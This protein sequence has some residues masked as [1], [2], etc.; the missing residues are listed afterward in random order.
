MSVKIKPITG[1]EP[2]WGDVK[3]TQSQ[4]D[5]IN[6][7]PT[8]V[9][10]LQ[11]ANERVAAGT[12]QPMAINPDLP[13]DGRYIYDKNQ[14]EFAP[15]VTQQS[16]GSFVNLLA[17]E[18]GHVANQPSDFAF[19]D[20]YIDTANPRDP[21]GYHNNGMWSL[22]N[23]TGGEYNGWKIGNEINGSLQ[24]AGKP[25]IEPDTSSPE[26]FDAFEAASKNRPAGLTDAQNDSRII[27]AGM[28]ASMVNDRHFTDGTY[29]YDGRQFSGL[30]PIEPGRPV[31][32]SFQSDPNT[33]D[34]TSSTENWKSGD[35]STQ[36]YQDGRLQSVQTVD[37]SGKPLQSSSYTYNPD[38]SYGMTVKDGAGQT[39]QQSDFNADKS[40]VERGFNADGSQLESQFNAQNRT[41]RMTQYDANGRETQKDYFDPNEARNTNQV[42]THPDGSRTLYSFNDLHKVGLQN[43][44]DAQGNR[45]GMS[46]YDPDTGRMNL[47]VRYNADGSRV[48]DTIDENG[49]G[50]RVS[51]DANG[52]RSPEQAMSY[53]P[54]QLQ[55]FKGQGDTAAGVA[56]P[57]PVGANNAL[58]GQKNYSDPATNRVTN[59]VVTEPDGS[60][61]LNSY[62]DQNTLGSRV[63]FDPNGNRVSARY[64]DPV[65]EAPNKNI[66]YQPDGSRSVTTPDNENL[67]MKTQSY[68]AKNQMTQAQ[69][70][71]PMGIQTTHYDPE[72]GAIT[73]Q[74]T[75]DPGGGHTI[76]SRNA[77]GNVGAI[78]SYD[79]TGK[80]T[81]STSYDPSDGSG[82]L[83]HVT[84][85]PDGSRAVDKATGTQH[86]S[87]TVGSDGQEQGRQTGALSPGNAATFAD[88]KKYATQT[89]DEGG[90]QTQ[91]T[92]PAPAQQPQDTSASGDNSQQTAAAPTNASDQQV[93]AEPPAVNTDSDTQPSA[94]ADD[95]APAADAEQATS[96]TAG[97]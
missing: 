59:Q 55:A 84:Y 6:R 72:T 81:S 24:A 4:L 10:Q 78:N 79:A 15:D 37:P 62:N 63:Q 40:G 22:L 65:T 20:K 45:T 97:A 33:G 25:G 92:Q 70:V 86:T 56:P 21:A 96:D 30:A 85:N 43:D 94:P 50:T 14:L 26:T 29:D 18:V 16:D 44:Y 87:Y 9:A 28:G 91:A 68:N 90:A 88:W 2:V 83:T 5:L 49:A 67:S 54:A 19:K 48:A 11:A 35:V 7:S 80:P 12:L 52:N 23:E 93:A 60:R 42:V 51:T 58:G 46:A 36:N 75:T 17:H 73:A 57:Q 61:T 69:N 8:F 13:A 32:A 95:A 39:L 77:Q 34:I 38:G 41:T 1:T 76:E 66:D 31:S 71:S 53:T 89:P 82:T 74:N 47:N 64:F 27:H 3:P